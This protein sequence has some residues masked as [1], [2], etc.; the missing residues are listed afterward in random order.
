MQEKLTAA[1]HYRS[2]DRMLGAG[3]S[4]CLLTVFSNNLQDTV[5]AVTRDQYKMDGKA[6]LLCV[7]LSR[8]R[9]SLGLGILKGGLCGQSDSA[10]KCLC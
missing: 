2:S 4:T 8:S 3:Q 1:T 10:G 9:R 7:S 5:Q 6:S